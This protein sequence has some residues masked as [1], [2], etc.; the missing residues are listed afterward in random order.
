MQTVVLDPEKSV[1][2]AITDGPMKG[3]KAVTLVPLGERTRIEV[4]WDIKL[5]G[6]IGM[7]GGVVKKHI[8][9]GTEDALNRIAKAVE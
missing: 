7:F 9:E 5:A 2:I 8:A 6:F 3:T 4:T 1:R